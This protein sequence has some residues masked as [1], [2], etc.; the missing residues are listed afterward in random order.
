M[1]RKGGR[2]LQGADSGLLWSAQVFQA[3]RKVHYVF[4]R[5][6]QGI[7]LHIHIH[8]LPLYQVNFIFIVV[9]TGGRIISTSVF[10]TS[11]SETKQFNPQATFQTY[12]WSRNLILFLVAQN[13]C[14]FFPTQHKISVITSNMK[15]KVDV[16]NWSFIFKVFVFADVFNCFDQRKSRQFQHL[17]SWE[18]VALGINEWKRCMLKKKLYFKSV[19]LLGSCLINF[20]NHC[21]W[22]LPMGWKD[23]KD[24]LIASFILLTH[25][26]GCRVFC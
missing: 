22:S 8:W 11:E 7:E 4:C 21:G 19:L 12:K 23:G 16:Y 10:Q 6:S 18:L 25:I 15:I 17:S 14:L 26:S 9:L 5:R 13:N 20:Y 1:A 3:A 2:L 24:K